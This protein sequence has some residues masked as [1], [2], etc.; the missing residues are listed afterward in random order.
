MKDL[1]K[2][3]PAFMYIEICLCVYIFLCTQAFIEQLLCVSFCHNIPSSKYM[4]VSKNWGTPKW[5]VYNGKPYY[6]IKMDDLGA[7]IFSETSIYTFQ[8]LIRPLNNGKKKQL[9][10]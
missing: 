10:V 4:G 9:F 6:H 2:N 7:S 1:H 8:K 3:M 5:M